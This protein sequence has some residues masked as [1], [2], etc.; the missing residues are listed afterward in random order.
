MRCDGFKLAFHFVADV[1]RVNEIGDAFSVYH[2]V[3]TG[4]GFQ[5]FIGLFIAFAAQDCLDGFGYD[6]PHIVEVAVDGCFVEEQFAQTMCC[7][8]Q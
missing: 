5:R 1:E 3:C 7:E 4:K 6:I 8:E 2:R